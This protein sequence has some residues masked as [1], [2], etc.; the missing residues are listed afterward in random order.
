MTKLITPELV[1]AQYQDTMILQRLLQANRERSW[2]EIHG[3]VIEA[4]G[5]DKARAQEAIRTA[6]NMLV[7]MSF[8]LRAGKLLAQL[9]NREGELEYLYETM[10]QVFR[11]SVGR[12]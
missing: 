4:Y 9:W 2:Y 5:G 12:G 10:A 7:G 8:Q 1:M 11:K 3:E 6:P